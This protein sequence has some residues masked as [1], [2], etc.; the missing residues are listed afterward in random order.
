MYLSTI[1]R[2]LRHISLKKEKRILRHLK[3]TSNY[4]VMY[5]KQEKVILTGWSDSDYAC[6][7]DDRKNTSGYVFMI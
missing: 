2:I 3:G 1:K 5:K 4:G 6:D 7:I